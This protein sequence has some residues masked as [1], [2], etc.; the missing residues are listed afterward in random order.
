MKKEEANQKNK[1]SSKEINA[2]NFGFPPT[3]ETTYQNSYNFNGRS[4]GDESDANN[5]VNTKA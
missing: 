5:K 2:S 3:A 1:D 4:S